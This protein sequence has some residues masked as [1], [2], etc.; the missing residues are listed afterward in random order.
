MWVDLRQGGRDRSQTLKNLP[1]RT[2]AGQFHTADVTHL[3]YQIISALR[4]TTDFIA[5]RVLNR[6][7]SLTL[8]APSGRMIHKRRSRHR[9]LG[10]LVSALKTV[11][12][13]FRR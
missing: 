5:R 11:N 1:S 13:G 3:A 7:N 4:I 10:S 12:N 9:P 8:S 2:R 6:I